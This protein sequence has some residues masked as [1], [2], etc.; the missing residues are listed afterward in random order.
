LSWPK[1]EFTRRWFVAL[2]INKHF[3]TV[4]THFVTRI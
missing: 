4:L 2:V 3:S 1:R